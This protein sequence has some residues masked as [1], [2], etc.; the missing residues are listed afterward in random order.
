MKRNLLTCIFILSISAIG[1]AQTTKVSVYN[2]LG[3][4]VI[5]KTVEF[6][7]ALDYQWCLYH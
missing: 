4:R 1:F 2:V 5:N 6:G 3:K 7:Q